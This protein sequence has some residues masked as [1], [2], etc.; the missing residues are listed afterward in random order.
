[1]NGRSGGEAILALLLGGAI[2]AGVGMLFA[3]QSGRETR[4]RVKVFFD[5]VGEKTG[6]IL[7][8]GRETVEEL[9]HPSKSTS[10]K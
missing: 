3:T 1:M 2:G 10:K 7:E 5:D 4:K 8:E 9:V 6:E